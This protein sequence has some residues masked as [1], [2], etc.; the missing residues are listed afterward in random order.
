VPKREVVLRV[1][2]THIP[3]FF[4]S[5]AVEEELKVFLHA[6]ILVKLLFHVLEMDEMERL[7]QEETLCACGGSM[8]EVE[9]FHTFIHIDT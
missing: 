8:E 3:V 1:C 4:C 2:R 5:I 9:V 7:L 6:S